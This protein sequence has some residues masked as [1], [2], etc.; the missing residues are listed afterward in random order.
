MCDKSNNNDKNNIIGINRNDL[1]IITNG[2][3][4]NITTISNVNQIGHVVNSENNN[5]SEITPLIMIINSSRKGW[6]ELIK[7]LI[8]IGADPNMKIQYYGKE[9]SANDIL[10]KY[11]KNVV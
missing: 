1:N 6:R 5:I 3:I 7:R 10:N 2:D 9:L 8:N 4:N 11:R